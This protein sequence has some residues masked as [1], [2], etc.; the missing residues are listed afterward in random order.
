MNIAKG[1]TE[2]T[3]LT[4]KMSCNEAHGQAMTEGGTGARSSKARSVGA[5]L[6]TGPKIL[7]C[8]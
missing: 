1:R 3:G 2:G 6:P 7:Y 4:G 8:S 5:A